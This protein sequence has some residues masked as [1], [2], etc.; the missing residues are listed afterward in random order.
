[1]DTLIED[2]IDF[3]LTNG[4]I[5]Y[6]SQFK[7]THAPLCLTPYPIDQQLLK[8]VEESTPVF[9]ELMVKVGSDR[10]FINEYLK[11]VAETDEF[12]R[13]LLKIYAAT[14]I[15]HHLQISRNDFLPSYDDK[16]GK[17]VLRQVEFNTISN[18]FVFLT[19]RMYLLHKH[20]NRQLNLKGQ[21][22]IN[23]TLA[24]TV[25]AM[26][27]VVTY[28][29]VPGSCLLMVVQE[30]EQNIFDQRGIEFQL[31]EKHGVKTIRKTLAEIADQ[32]RHKNGHLV[33][34]DE[35]IALVYYRAG[36]SPMDYPNEG[37]WQGRSLIENSSVIKCPSIGMQ[38]AGAKKIQQALARTGM[39]ERYLTQ[40]Q[41]RLLKDSFVGMYDLDER[42]D[43]IPAQELALRSPDDFV[44]KPQREGGGNNL[45]GAEIIAGIRAMTREQK[46]AYVLMERIQSPL[47]NALLVVDRMIEQTLTIS[48]IGRFGACFYD[49]SAIRI[50]KDVGYLVRTKSSSQ[51]EGGV[52]AGYACLNS[53][54]LK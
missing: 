18:S 2:A 8:F 45:Y 4:L 30:R 20:L 43:G 14:E 11:P 48:E 9:N 26:A 39:L 31:W 12:I 17:Y 28:Y 27:E 47:E 24:E 53:L 46:K 29:D 34:G 33:V 21:L 50:N 44:L 38:L 22:V 49:G 36:Y 5:K 35:P 51:N 15:S 10:D 52:C 41:A 19:Q 40:D 1:M 54:C 42:V 25:S 32:G 37:A 23:N 3:A 6:N 16:A 7:L 13:R